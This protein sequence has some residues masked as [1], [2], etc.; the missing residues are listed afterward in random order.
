GPYAS[1]DREGSV[2]GPQLWT[3]FGGSLFS[4]FELSHSCELYPFRLSRCRALPKNCSRPN[5]A[6]RDTTIFYGIGGEFSRC[7]ANHWSCF[8]Q[9]AA[10]QAFC[11]CGKSY[12]CQFTPLSGLDIKLGSRSEYRCSHRHRHGKLH[13]FRS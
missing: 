10:T 8:R 3:S 1:T 12:C 11:D 13:C 5:G 2:S 6:T 9:I 7:F 4:L